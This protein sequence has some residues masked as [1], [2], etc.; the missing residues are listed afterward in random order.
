[1]ALIISC[2]N[3]SGYEFIIYEEKNAKLWVEDYNWDMSFEFLWW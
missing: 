1:M 2:T 3:Q